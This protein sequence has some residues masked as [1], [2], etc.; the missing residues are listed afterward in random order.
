M[1]NLLTMCFAALASAS[2]LSATVKTATQPWVEA[3]ISDATNATLSAA[4]SAASAAISA[5]TNGLVTA[6]VTNGLA[7]QSSLTSLSSR[8]DAKRDK[9]DLAVY[10]KYVKWYIVETSGDG[11]L[12]EPI[13]MYDHGGYTF[14]CD[15][16]NV[17]GDE[18]HPNRIVCD[19]E[20][21]DDGKV[22]AVSGSGETWWPGV[23]G[24][25]PG[26]TMA[27]VDMDTDAANLINDPAN[28][29][30]SA[31]VQYYDADGNVQYGMVRFRVT[32]TGGPHELA[33]T[34][35]KTSDLTAVSN[36]IPTA[37]SGLSDAGD[38]LKT[39]DLAKKETD[40]SFNAW[41]NGNNIVAGYGAEPAHD[42][43]IACSVVIGREARTGD[44]ANCVA[45][46]YEANAYGT[47]TVAIGANANPQGNE[48]ISIGVSSKASGE[49]G[50]A[51]GH[52]AT[53]SAYSF[54]VGSGAA[55][56]G[57]YAV[58]LGYGTTATWGSVAIGVHRDRTG[59][60][61]ASATNRT[62]VAFAYYPNEFWLGSYKD[63][64][65]AR[66]LQSYLDE[67]ATTKDLADVKAMISATD[68]TFSNAVLQVGI[69]T[70]GIT[71]NDLQV[72]HDLAEL[73]VGTSITTV[74]GLLAALAAG[75]AALKKSVSTLSSKVD[76]ANAALEEVA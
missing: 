21:G 13:E 24:N 18:L 66:S 20:Y 58:A 64:T 41:T 70:L 46:G 12:S 75:L 59:Y 43:P 61:A 10:G 57:G 60:V 54:A 3:K 7:S 37:V 14:S 44:G 49:K 47:K 35:A 38:Y 48:S 23:D 63:S 36:A 17:S 25:E 6:S 4:Q 73:P 50:I 55:A 19:T 52:D 15:K 45:I 69:G 74:G 62:S 65:D 53:A 72:V 8:V 56:K 26:Y 9:T 28:G 29:E 71:T 11:R 5:A 51:L 42:N 16:V 34:L 40:P 2:A 22:S 30:F 27:S 68:A 31:F 67:R 1:R 76:D 39:A 32:Y 33:D